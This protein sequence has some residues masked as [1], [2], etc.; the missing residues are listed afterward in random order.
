MPIDFTPD[1]VESGIDFKPDEI[2][3]GLGA[4]I[5]RNAPLAQLDIIQALKDEWAGKRDPGGSFRAG[6]KNPLLGVFSPATA[7]G[8]AV[9]VSKAGPKILSALES[10][11]TSPL[12]ARAAHM[13]ENVLSALLKRTGVSE[14]AARPLKFLLGKAVDVANPVGQ[15]GRLTMGAQKAIAVALD[16][17]P[18]LLGRFAPVLKEAAKQGSLPIAIEALANEEP[19][20]QTILAN[21]GGK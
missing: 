3:L 4:S 8:G 10:A 12:P 13:G 20:F 14:G 16:K 11:A 2:E 1:P 7:A 6:T 15:A 9:A 17:S 19:E 5:D 18:Q 21:I